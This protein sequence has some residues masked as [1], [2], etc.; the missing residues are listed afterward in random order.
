[1]LENMASVVA[2]SAEPGQSPI[3]AY[4]QTLL[5]LTRAYE[6]G[7][8]GGLVNERIAHQLETHGINFRPWMEEHLGLLPE[9]TTAG[10]I[11][12]LSKEQRADVDAALYKKI[13]NTK[14]GGVGFYWFDEWMKQQNE[15]GGKFFGG[16]E[17][18]GKTTGGV[19]SGT[20]DMLSFMQIQVGNIINGPL[21]SLMDAFNT[22]IAAIQKCKRCLTTLLA[23]FRLRLTRRRYHKLSI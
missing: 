18:A 1:M 12:T 19:E 14:K 8:V 2:P 5:E 6:R 10:N 15:P 17:A 23:N 16:A 9:G 3:Q 21:K 4:N 11:E 20:A 22:T 13:S 7:E